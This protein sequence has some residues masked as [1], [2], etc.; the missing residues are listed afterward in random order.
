MSQGRALPFGL[1]GLGAALA[2]LVLL[3]LGVNAAGGQLRSGGFVLGLFLLVL[4]GGPPLAVGL[5]LLSRSKG[6]EQA[7]QTFDSQ[8]RVIDADRLLRT[9]LARN[10]R[11]LAERVAGPD[12]Q[13]AARLRD[14]AE[15]LERP[16]YDQASWY[17][18]ITLDAE[19][20]QQVQRYDDLLVEEQRR[21]EQA[22]RDLERGQAGAGAA[23]DQAL[24]RWEQQFRRRQD[25]LLRGRKA[26]GMAAS[27]LLRAG[28]PSRGASA[29]AALKLRDAV[30]Y[31][32]DDYVVETSTTYFA[33]GR[34]WNIYTLRT[35][36]SDERYLYVGP[37]GADLALLEPAT[38]P[39]PLGAER[40]DGECSLAENGSAT[41]TIVGPRGSGEGLLV[42]YWRYDC[43]Q[44]RLAWV[45]HWQEGAP[46][47]F[48]GAPINPAAFEVWPSA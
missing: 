4:L 44:Q 1:I 39:D 30:S 45:E 9:D 41:A 48:A 43:P 34:T 6:E 3:W 15:D 21:A 38:V 23:L 37:G 24:D 32:D 13:A 19:A 14:L 16:G 31:E 27:D 5:Y 8:R 17:E 7:Q 10:F 33:S 40:F 46:R 36:R 22:A 35:A 18:T 12:A 11:Q 20:Q 25:L 29:L 26:P 47:A 42:D 2:V 28:T